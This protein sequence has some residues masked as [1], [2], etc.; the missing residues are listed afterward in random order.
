MN[1][2]DDPLSAIG[3]VLLVNISSFLVNI[4]NPVLGTLSLIISCVYVSFK[5]YREYK[6]G[7]GEEPEEPEDK[8]L[9]V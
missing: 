9:N 5:L 7:T 6:E 2:V 4:F 1:N 8:N 3:T